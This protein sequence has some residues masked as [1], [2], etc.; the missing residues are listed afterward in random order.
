[1]FKWLQNSPFYVCRKIMILSNSIIKLNAARRARSVRFWFRS[2]FYSKRI[3][4]FIIWIII[5]DNWTTCLLI[6]FVMLI[7]EY[8]HS[9]YYFQE[10]I[11]NN[12][13]HCVNGHTWQPKYNKHIIECLDIHLKYDQLPLYRWYKT[14]TTCFSA[15]SIVT[16]VTHNKSI[17]N[18]LLLA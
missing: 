11:G 13:S 9:L 18:I 14:Y 15:V 16:M 6:V 10:L 2:L 7:A 3:A 4:F 5:A 12:L 8:L 1:M 17:C